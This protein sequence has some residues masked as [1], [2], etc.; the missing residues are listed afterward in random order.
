MRRNGFD[1]AQAVTLMEIFCDGSTASMLRTSPITT[2]YKGPF[3]HHPYQL[4]SDLG[5]P[6][7]RRAPPKFLDA[8]GDAAT[9]VHTDLYF[10]RMKAPGF[11][12]PAKK[13]ILL[14]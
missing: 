14:K 11:I 10:Y 9:T 8:P 2:K 12:S 7:Q 5:T 3:L 6:C 1:S 13:M 4:L